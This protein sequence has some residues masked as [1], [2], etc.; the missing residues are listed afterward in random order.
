MKG[1]VGWRAARPLFPL[2][3]VS[4]VSGGESRADSRRGLRRLMLKKL[5]SSLAQLW[6]P[7]LGPDVPSGPGLCTWNSKNQ[8]TFMEG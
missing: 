5:L 7:L 4:E 8:F 3:R 2:C 1:G 6:Q